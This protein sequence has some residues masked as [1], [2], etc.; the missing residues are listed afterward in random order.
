MAI[1]SPEPSPGNP[2]EISRADPVPRAPANR[3]VTL[4]LVAASIGVVPGFELTSRHQGRRA[5]LAADKLNRHIGGLGQMPLP[6]APGSAGPARAGWG[7]RAAAF[8][9]AD[10]QLFP[11]S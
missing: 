11:P 9:R 8:E 4:I 5:L 7:R 3:L 2:P 10:R 6:V 1:E